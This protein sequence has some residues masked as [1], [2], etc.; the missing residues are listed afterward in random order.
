MLLTIYRVVSQRQVVQQGLLRFIR[1]HGPRLAPKDDL[2]LQRVAG[3]DS[4]REKELANI[5]VA[6][7]DGDVRQI[8]CKREIAAHGLKRL[9][10]AHMS[11]GRIDRDSRTGKPGART[12]RRPV[13]GRVY[14]LFPDIDP[15]GRMF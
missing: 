2:K 13:L 7:A 8:A 10:R 3:H 15:D 9:N 14:R 6:I 12:L 4:F 5:H 11:V 1:Q